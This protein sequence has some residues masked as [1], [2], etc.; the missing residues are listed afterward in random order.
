MN[1][2]PSRHDRAHE[3]LVALYVLQAVPADEQRDVEVSING[4]RECRDEL[5]GLRSTLASF[6][7]WPTDVLRPTRDLWPRLTQR[8]AAE[9]NADAVSTPERTVSADWQ[10]AGVGVLYQVLAVDRE[11][12]RV[13][14]LVKLLPGAAYPP[15]A[16]AGIEELYLLDGELWIDSKKLH[17]GDY[18][19]A[20][21]GSSDQRVWSETGCTCVLLTS[22]ED[23]LH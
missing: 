15:H 13:S 21:V 8:I 23:L 10:E 12:A 17:P 20:G 2:E 18:N 22:T 5:E 16:H 7:G 19:R 6:V 11:R 4:C 1:A 9:K 14:L 3:E